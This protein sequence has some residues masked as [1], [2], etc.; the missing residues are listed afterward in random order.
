MHE[1]PVDRVVRPDAWIDA[2]VTTGETP[3]NEFIAVSERTVR[4]GKDRRFPSYGWDNEY[5]FHHA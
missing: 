1:L 3:K 4:Y 5:V 2:P